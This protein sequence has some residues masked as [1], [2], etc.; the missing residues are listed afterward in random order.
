MD[1]LSPKNNIYR[2]I[3]I[4]DIHLG[5]SGA[6]AEH[7]LEFLKYNESKYLYLVG[8]IIDGWRLTKKWYWPQSHNAVSYTHLTL[9][10]IYSV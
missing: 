4:S 8:D 2:A 6:Q 3:W 1:Q 9:P 7:L 5:S 10:T